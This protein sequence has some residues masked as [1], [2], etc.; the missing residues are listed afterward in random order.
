MPRL[1]PRCGDVAVRRTGNQWLCRRH[2]RFQQMRGN[3]RR[4]GLLIPTYETLDLLLAGLKDRQCPHCARQMNWLAVEGQSTVMTLQHYRDGSLG[5]ICRACNTRHA[6][7][8]G[9][10]FVTLPRG[11]KWCSVCKTQKPLDQ[12]GTDNSGKWLGKRSSCRDCHNSTR[13]LDPAGPDR[14]QVKTYRVQQVT[15]GLRAG[16]R[17]KDI[18]ASLGLRPAAVSQIIKRNRLAELAN[19]GESTPSTGEPT[20]GEKEGENNNPETPTA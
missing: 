18:A 10:T 4:R 2:Y 9:D 20:D 7:M 17:K 12:F 16:Y 14:Q 8:P 19:R 1:C 5:L 11:M 13:R 3:A 6:H 15:L